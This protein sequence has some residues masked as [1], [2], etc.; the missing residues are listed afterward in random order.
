MLRRRFVLPFALVLIAL[1]GVACA[2]LPS[3]RRTSPA[4][5]VPR[6][7]VISAFEP[8]LVKLRAATTITGTRVIN[9]RTHYLGSLAGHDVVLLLSGFSMVNAAMTTQAMLDRFH[10]SAIVFSGI[11]GGVNPG[12]DVGDVTVPAQWGN[13]QESVFAR[14]TPNGFAPARI[15]TPFANFGMMYT[16]GSSV[17]MPVGK[18]DSLERRFWFPVDTTALSTARRIV[19]TVHL[20]RCTAAGACLAHEPRIVIGGN[21]VSGP[22]FVDNAAYRE[23]AWNTFHADALDM[24]TAAVAVVAFENRV[25]Y[26]AF[27]SLSDLAGGGG[28]ANE[29]QVFGRLAADN[30]AAV[31]IEY[32]KAL[33]AK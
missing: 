6:I 24:E 33:P 20:A 25:P 21:G 17:A 16:Q 19:S 28:G 29:A 31:V 2:T 11:A 22:T 9:G 12:L 1:G 15:T 32:L 10:V 3:T 30:S 8:E 26:I 13:Y 14:E 27:R 7:A 23:W 18:A 5:D 4:D